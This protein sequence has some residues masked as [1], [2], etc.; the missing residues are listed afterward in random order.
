[1]AARFCVATRPCVIR[2]SIVRN[3]W[4]CSCLR[5]R[6][7]HLSHC[8]DAC[9]ALMLCRSLM[10]SKRGWQLLGDLHVLEI[11]TL[12]GTGA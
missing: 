5:A 12:L 1:M 9:C 3:T 7:A 6:K 11:E 4:H 2:V 10:L 8:A